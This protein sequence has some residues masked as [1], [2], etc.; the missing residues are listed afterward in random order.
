MRRGPAPAAQLARLLPPTRPPP[1]PR[2]NP[3]NIPYK[4]AFMKYDPVVRQHVL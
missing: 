1:P 4:L 3:T 2:R